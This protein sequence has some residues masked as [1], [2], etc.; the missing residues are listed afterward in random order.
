MKLSRIYTS[1][2]N[3]DKKIRFVVSSGLLTAL[4]LLSTLFLFDVA[5]VW[6]PVFILSTYTAV[7]FSVFEDIEKIEWLMLFLIPVLFT[8]VFYV[9]YFLFPVRWLTRIP[10]MIFYFISILTLLRAK[11]IFNVGV[12]KSLQLY[13]AAF[14]VNFFFHTVILFFVSSILFSL[15]QVYIVN[16][17]VIGVTCFILSLQFFWTIRLRLWIDGEIFRYALL[18]GLVL[19]ETATLLSFLPIPAPICTLLLT[20]G[21]YS[22][23]GLSYAFIDERFFKETVREYLIVLVFVF[24][25]SIIASIRF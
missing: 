16:G 24:I 1:I 11:N 6:I 8:V 7:Y 2:L 19:F 4:M 9:F 23:C 12:E 3:V 21:Y 18:V 17:L 25:I 13:R 15:R 22:I 14:S 10:F 20:A 5:F